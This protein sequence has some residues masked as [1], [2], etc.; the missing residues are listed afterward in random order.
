MDALS[1]PALAIA[2][3]LILILGWLALVVNG[4]RPVR[5]TFK[6][7]G[8]DVKVTPCSSG[9]QCLEEQNEAG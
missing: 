5:I 8:L 2:T 7:L 3:V 9:G 1:Y 4:K 6:G